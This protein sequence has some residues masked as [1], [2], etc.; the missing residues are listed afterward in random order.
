MKHE[1]VSATASEAVA[2]MIKRLRAEREAARDEANAAYGMA[3]K[4]LIEVRELRRQRLAYG[5][6]FLGMLLVS[7]LREM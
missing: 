7:V 6:A 1:V 5:L 4:V 3:H 2:A